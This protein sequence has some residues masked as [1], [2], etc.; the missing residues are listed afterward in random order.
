M[1]ELNSGEGLTVSVVDP[2]SDQH[3]L[4][5]R[6]DLHW[7]NLLLL[8]CNASPLSPRSDRLRDA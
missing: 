5:A 3:L 4:G 1:L 2:R 8:Q 6:Y 7:K